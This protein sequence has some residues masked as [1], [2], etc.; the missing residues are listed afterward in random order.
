MSEI[1]KRT[2]EIEADDFAIDGQRRDTQR[3]NQQQRC[4]VRA[5]NTPRF[6]VRDFVFS[7]HEVDC[8]FATTNTPRK[9]VIAS[10]LVKSMCDGVA[11][12]KRFIATM[13]A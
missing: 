7:N 5:A 8:S 1:E 2:S 9:C 12:T 11:E 3:A 10:R 6:F 4:E 13:I